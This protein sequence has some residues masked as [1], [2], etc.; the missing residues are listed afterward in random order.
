[1]RHIAQVAALSMVLDVAYAYKNMP[2]SSF[3]FC[4]LHHTMRASIYFG[5]MPCNDSNG[6]IMQTYL[7]LP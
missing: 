1:M 6:N 3:D 7:A 4:T 2:N 5:V